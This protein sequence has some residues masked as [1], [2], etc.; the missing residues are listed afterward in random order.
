VPL[1]EGKNWWYCTWP[2]DGQG[3]VV[4][5]ESRVP[6]ALMRTNRRN[7]LGLTAP[8]S[9]P[10]DLAETNHCPA[11][12]MALPCPKHGA[13]GDRRFH[14]SSPA[15]QHTTNPTTIIIPRGHLPACQPAMSTPPRYTEA[16]HS[17]FVFLLSWS[18]YDWHLS[19]HRHAKMIQY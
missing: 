8:I 16:L 18:T 3:L 11:G 9:P 1:V 12:T 17:P 13:E 7:G 5:G 19:S 4:M 6:P 15:S 14:A 10:L 2:G